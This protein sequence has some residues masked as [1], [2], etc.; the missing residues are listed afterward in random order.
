MDG[1]TID[2]TDAVDVDNLSSS[3][4]WMEYLNSTLTA[5]DAEHTLDLTAGGLQL[6]AGTSATEATALFNA[7]QALNP[8]LK[9][10]IETIKIK[11]ASGD[12]G[13]GALA[14]SGSLD[15][16]AGF[17]ALARIIVDVTDAETS[18]VGQQKTIDFSGVTVEAA[19][20]T[21]VNYLFNQTAKWSGHAAP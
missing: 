3:A 5:A 4:E 1:V 9:A 15:I 14:L 19:V 8:T 7:L 20:K 17:T 21:G 2:N 10:K 6:A 13:D 18:S 11:L 12:H 16:A